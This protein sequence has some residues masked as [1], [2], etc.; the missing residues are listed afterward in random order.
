M[1][2][3][4]VPGYSP[5]TEEEKRTALRQVLDSSTL[6]KHKQL[7]RFLEYICELEIVGRRD[8]LREHLIGVHVL[9]KPEGYSTGE[10]AAVRGR[11][12]ALRRKL[13]ELYAD[14]MRS[15]PI[16]IDLPKGC[17]VPR[18]VRQE[19]PVQVDRA[20][21]PSSVSS[22]RSIL[23]R[24][25]IFHI[26]PFLV[27]MI[28]ATSVFLL[29]IPPLRRDQA[30]PPVIREVWGPLLDPSETA[31]LY[32]ATP[33]Q[34][35]V[36]RLPPDARERI[37]LQMPDAPEMRLWYFNRYSP[38]PGADPYLIPTYSSPTWG[39]MAGALSVVAVF[40]ASRTRYQ[41]L[42]EWISR[43]FA[44]RN[45]NAVVL[46]RPEYS[47]AAALLLSDTPLGIEYSAVHKAH[48]IVWRKASQDTQ[49]VLANVGDI[50][51]YG[52]GLVSVLPGQGQG[53][54]T[55]RIILFSGLNSAGTQAAAEFFSSAERLE[56]L[57]TLWRNDGYHRFP[58]AY[59]LVVKAR[60]PDILPMNVELVA[61]VVI[62]K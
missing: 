34:F 7:R 62:E 58:R 33:A 12:H 23:G 51:Q 37:K 9:G 48:V 15:T 55:R 29:I 47:P 26:A 6:Q 13:D 4:L 59:Q 61:R 21:A 1:E 40:A 45:R 27:G 41:L 42:P 16:R 50:T 46:G 49:K 3:R 25:W 22:E 43:P 57:R 60:A 38:Q 54:T 28:A 52:Y 56:E 39:E 19:V 24:K 53:S 11:A 5:V 14:E 8:E 35:F 36:R 18:F 44:L 31:L 2:N 10:D 30:L 17:Y 32:V 20:R